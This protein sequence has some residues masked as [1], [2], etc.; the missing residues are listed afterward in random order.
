MLP[1]EITA[2]LSCRYV[3]NNDPFLLFA[4][5][6]VEEVYSEPRIVIFHDVMSDS[7]IST[8][9]KLAQPRVSTFYILY[10][11]NIP[12]THILIWFVMNFICYFTKK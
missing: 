5:F 11:S 8:V 10:H 6:K 12:K 7:E 3:N 4:P 2:K 1:E 9:K